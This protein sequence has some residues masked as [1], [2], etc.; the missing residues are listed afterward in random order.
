MALKA[1]QKA[2]IKAVFGEKMSTSLFI[3]LIALFPELLKTVLEL[4]AVWKEHKV[5]RKPIKLMDDIDPDKPDP[6]TTPDPPQ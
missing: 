1:E 4:I 3:K 2:D 5:K 6:G